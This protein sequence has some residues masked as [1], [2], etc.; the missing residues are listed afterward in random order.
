[1]T[2]DSNGGA[3]R[4]PLDDDRTTSGA[5]VARRE[6]TRPEE[7]ADQPWTSAE[8]TRAAAPSVGASRDITGEREVERGA[9]DELTAAQQLQAFST[10]LIR[11]QEP[12]ALYAQLLDAAIALMQADAA[13]VQRLDPEGPRLRLLAS[14]NFHPQSELFWRWVDASSSSSCGQALA[15]NGRVVIEDTEVSAGMA[16]T[17]DLAEFRRCGLRAAQSTPLVSRNG[18]RLGMLSTH[19][20]EPRRPRPKDFALFDVLA[21]QAADLIERSQAEAALRQSEQHLRQ[22][23]E[24]LEVRVRERTVE[25]NELVTRLIDAHEEERRRIAQD[26]HD[27]VGQQMTALRMNLE[28]LQTHAAGRP[29]LMEQAE[30]TQRIAEALDQSIDFLTWQLRPAALDHLGLPAALQ[31]LVREWSARFAIAAEFVPDGGDERLPRHVEANLYRIVQE[32]LLNIAKHAD[33]THVVVTLSNRP[34]Q[35]TLVIE[36]NGRGFHPRSTSAERGQAGLGLVGMRERAAL[37]GGRLEV[38]SAPDHGTSICV[39]VPETDVI[40]DGM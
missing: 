13:S 38:D 17:Q 10:R 16:N 29:A 5:E 34:G 32:A 11:E 22:L 31:N 28:A 6:H 23:N 27:Q 3:A 20:R 7:T 26:I 15:A 12:D 40:P 37:L 25:I 18:E 14:R 4:H 39:S 36:D 35:L 1:M 24:R 19:W 2:A 9:A 21:R 30:R 8:R 33:A